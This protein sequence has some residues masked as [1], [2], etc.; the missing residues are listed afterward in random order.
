VNIFGGSQLEDN[1][2]VVRIRS[3]GHLAARANLNGR[4]ELDLP[5][6]QRHGVE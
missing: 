3:K 6:P 2:Y 4:T 5:Q 1:I